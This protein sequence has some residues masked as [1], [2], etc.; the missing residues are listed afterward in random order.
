MLAFPRLLRFF[1]FC[2]FCDE[3]P[4][5]PRKAPAS[6]DAQKGKVGEMWAGDERAMNALIRFRQGRLWLA[7]NRKGKLGQPSW[8]VGDR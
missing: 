7:R 3:R 2:L 6:D 1:T 4:G 8:Q 5:A